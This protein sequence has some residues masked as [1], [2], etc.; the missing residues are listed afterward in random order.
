MH[1]CVY[2][3]ARLSARRLGET[4]EWGSFLYVKKDFTKLL[5]R[6]LKKAKRGLCLL[7]SITDPYQ[8]IEAELKLTRSILELLAGKMDVVVLTKSPLVLR[9][10]DIISSQRWQAG[11]T[12]TTLDDSAARVFEPK[13]PPPSQ[14]IRALREVARKTTGFMF[15][16]P[17]LPVVT[18][19]DLEQLFEEAASAGASYVLVDKLNIKA[20]NWR[21]IQK[22]LKTHMP[23]LIPLFKKA[24]F[25]DKAY[26]HRLKQRAAELS[27]KYG[28][29]VEFCY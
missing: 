4:R 5:A 1:G 7:S 3:Y 27:R 21:S 14:R 12:I 2:C 13:A 18:E 22:A 29:Q 26:Y 10:L 11:L 20:G 16:G 15:I 24:L 17:I 23:K 19:K 9:D 8:P 28:V 6:D 25:T